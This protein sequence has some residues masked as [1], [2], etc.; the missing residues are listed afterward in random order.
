MMVTMVDNLECE[1][2]IGNTDSNPD[3]ISE[4]WDI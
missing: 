2:M 1:C 4:Q 3:Y